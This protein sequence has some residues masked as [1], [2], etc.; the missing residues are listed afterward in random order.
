MCSPRIFFSKKNRIGGMYETL[1]EI[2]C[3]EMM[4]LNAVEEIT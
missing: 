1:N 3:R 2:V 4:A